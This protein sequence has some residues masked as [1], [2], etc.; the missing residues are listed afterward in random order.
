[1]Q[2]VGVDGCAKDTGSRHVISGCT[3]VTDGAG[4][5]CRTCSTRRNA[6]AGEAVR[7]GISARTA[8]SPIDVISRTA[9]AA[10]IASIARLA[11]SAV[12]AIS[13]GDAVS[14]DCCA[15][16]A[17]STV[18]KVVGHTGGTVCS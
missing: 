10:C 12:S 6:G 11:G 17:I 15:E 18:E 1:M 4:I 14:A 16:S 7:V 9:R 3:S 2:T 8:V 13:A 5:A